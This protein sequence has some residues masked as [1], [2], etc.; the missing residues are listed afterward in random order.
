MRAGPCSIHMMD[1]R[2]RKGPKGRACRMDRFV[3][4]LI[5]IITNKAETE[6][7]NKIMGSAG[8]G[9]KTAPINIKSLMSP[10]PIPSF[11]RSILQSKE[12]SKRLPPPKKEPRKEAFQD[13]VAVGSMIPIPYIPAI[14]NGTG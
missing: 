4:I 10:M 11:F 5:G 9:P 8:Q 12:I 13:I 7:K 3:K 6:D 1:A 2:D 14:K